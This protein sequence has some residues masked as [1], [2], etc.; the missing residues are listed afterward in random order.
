MNILTIQKKSRDLEDFIK[1]AKRKLVEFDVLQSQW[2]IAQ[3]KG[4]VH[5]SV[6]DFMKHIKSKLK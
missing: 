5:S 6:S 2:E 3:G 4:K 1:K